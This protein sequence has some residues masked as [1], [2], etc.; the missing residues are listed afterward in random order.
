M[1]HERTINQPS[2]AAVSSFGSHSKMPARITLTLRVI[3]TSADL[4][5]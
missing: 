2:K 4:E 5:S 3:R 1:H